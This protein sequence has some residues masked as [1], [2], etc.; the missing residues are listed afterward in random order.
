MQ[1]APLYPLIH[2]FLKPTFPNCL[3]AGSLE[4]K[5]VA[6]TFDDGPHPQY[7]PKLLEVLDQYQIP[8]SFFW[9]GTCVDR[10]PEVA[11]AVW[12]R[13]HWL[14]L[15]G[16]RHRSFTQL[17]TL[18]LR[19]SLIQTQTAIAQ[20]CRLDLDEVQQ[21]IRDVRPPNGFFTPQ[22]LR[23]LEQWNYRPVM[24]SVVPEDWVRPGIDTVVQRVLQQTQNGS[25][26]VLHDGYCGGEDVAETAA[27]LI[28]ELL[29]QGYTF[30][31]VDHFWQC[32]C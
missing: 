7:T 11:Q 27:Q 30:V 29:A 26:I 14:G 31:T 24:W 10:S 1:F 25:L 23:L 17:S 16:Y 5:T 3:W 2:Q 18:G 19:Q 28:P 6:L 9:L 20:A 22:T 21:H 32:R 12:Q 4:T 15:H 13:G 8:A